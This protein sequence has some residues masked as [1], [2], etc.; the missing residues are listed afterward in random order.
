MGIKAVTKQEVNDRVIIGV[1]LF[2]RLII[3]F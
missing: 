3:F 2:Y 1:Y